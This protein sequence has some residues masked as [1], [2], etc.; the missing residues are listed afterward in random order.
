MATKGGEVSDEDATRVMA[1]GMTL[2]TQWERDTQ[3]RWALLSLRDAGYRI[4]R[5]DQ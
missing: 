2:P 3:A 1:Q 4:V 5:A